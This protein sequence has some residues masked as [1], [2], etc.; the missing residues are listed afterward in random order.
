MVGRRCPRTRRRVGRAS[1]ECCEGCSCRIRDRRDATRCRSSV[2]ARA[3]WRLGKVADGPVSR[4]RCHCGGRLTCSASLHDS[5]TGLATIPRIR[6]CSA[7]A[8]ERR[9]APEQDTHGTALD[10][11]PSDHLNPPSTHVECGFKS[12]PGHD[13]AGSFQG[14]QT[15]DARKIAKVH[16]RFTALRGRERF[17]NGS[18]VGVPQERRLGISVSTLAST[19]NLS[20]PA[21]APV[22]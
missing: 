5:C 1:R 20:G 10:G 9:A 3:R 16:K 19:L 14:R 7:D 21:A 11:R 6:A 13:L 15:S 18:R 8:S 2:Q 22:Q 4:R 12:R 17:S